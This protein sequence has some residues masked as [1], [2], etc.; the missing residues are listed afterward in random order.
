[1]LKNIR[2]LGRSPSDT[3]SSDK[4]SDKGKDKKP[5]MPATEYSLTDPL[6]KNRV[7]AATNHTDAAALLSMAKSDDS[8]LVRDT[9]TRRYSQLITDNETERQ[10]L[11]DLLA[12]HRALFFSITTQST[13]ESLRQLGLEKATNDEDWLIIAD[14][15]KFHD[16]RLTAANKLDTLASVDKC[17][18]SMKTKD[19][20]VAR[21]LKTR[22]DKHREEQS[23]ADAQESQVD[24]LLDEMDKIANGIWQPGTVNRFDLFSTQWDQLDFEPASDKKARYVT[25]HQSASEKAKEWRGKQSLQD[26]RLSVIATLK[27]LTES[28]DKA[29]AEELSTL[30]PACTSSLA[31][32]RK[33]WA[34]LQ[35][36]AE[37]GQTQQFNTL[38]SSIDSKLKN[39]ATVLKAQQLL[40]N[41][42]PAPKALQS[43]LKSL[44][45]LRADTGTA[46]FQK[47]APQLID[48]VKTRLDQK[49]AA[50]TELRQQ[51]HRQFASLNSAVAAKR[52]GPA[53][54]IQERLAKK[55]ARL[56]AS[57]K[58]GYTEKLARLETKV[59]ELGDW[60]E[61][62]SEPKLIT[63][64]EQMEKVPSQ[65][66]PPN[67]C[68][69]RIK[70]LQ[71]QWKAMGASPAQEQHWPRF[72]EAADIAYEPCG[73][74]FTARREDRKIKLDKRKEICEL[75][76]QYE[77]NTD[78]TQPDFKLV[79]KTLRTAKQEWK[80]NQVFDKKRGKALDDRFTKILT[81]LDGKLD[82][83]YEANA[84]E[85]KDLIERVTKLGEGDIN[86][87][88]INQVKSLQSAWRLSGAC[89]QKDDRALWKEFSA[90][91]NQVFEKF[92]GIKREQHAASVEHVVRAR[93][94]IRTLATIKDSKEPVSE[95][96]LTD[97][98]TEYAELPEF[99]ERDQKRLERD[100]RKALDSVDRYRQQ[101]L[102]NSRKQAL[103]SLQHNADLCQQLESLAGQP[104][105]EIKDQMETILSEWQSSNRGEN[106]QAVKALDA[107]KQA[108]VDLLNAGDTPDY[109][110]NTTARRLLCI[111]L[112]ILCDKETPSEDKAIRMQ[113]Q[114]EQLQQGLQSNSA[115]QSKAQRTEQ[116]QI[117]WLT[118]APAAPELRDKLE[119]RFN[120]VLGKN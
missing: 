65:K 110:T 38:S 23:L 47:A 76:E 75:L 9:C 37:A 15:S 83:V 62:A 111:E 116:L 17:W 36:E 14:K 119:S 88:G 79:E 100:L 85:K 50:D 10:T 32:Q 93:E 108:I 51:I 67:D 90:A 5:A 66:L 115:A 109:D 63:L 102:D 20:L 68:A 3:K 64:C 97:L 94:I 107:R 41:D 6:E 12:N 13:E 22:L 59:K 87:H 39:A 57:D 61:F 118:A 98:Q 18:R 44:E 117:K 89:R 86:Q 53:K 40:S 42:S 31:T 25:L 49:T 80:H 74:F 91:T 77:S 1:M 30:L 4:G 60:K 69:N 92:R 16:T 103:Q 84:A 45:A 82:P 26:Q 112:E 35:A 2:Q 95:K 21:E 104:A 105:E 71:M 33:L 56:P 52:W 11:A 54:S 43:T 96:T 72:K 73:K 55:I 8:E 101:T 28:T 120:Q 7:K 24:K 27:E 114:L 58:A 70:D 46:E 113:Y 34:D 81:L 29:T 78:W 48:T 19:K 106:P 99:P